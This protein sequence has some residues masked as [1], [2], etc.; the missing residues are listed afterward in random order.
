LVGK[1]KNLIYS[2]TI[3]HG[4]SPHDASDIFQSVIADLLSNLASLRN[5]SALPAW[6]IQ[7]TSHRCTRWK[8]LQLRE[9]PV[10]NDDSQ[11]GPAAGSWQTPESLAHEAERE[12]MLR[13]AVH[14]ATPRCREL[15]HMLFYETPMRPYAEVAASLG[16]ALGSISFLRRRCLDRLRTFLDRTGF[17]AP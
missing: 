11:V 3:R 14:R 7:V 17:S 8:R 4:L 9:I 13:E 5:A 2:I 15:I 1:Y 6:L 12:Q 10:A 16:V